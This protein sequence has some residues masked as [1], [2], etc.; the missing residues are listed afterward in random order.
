MMNKKGQWIHAYMREQR[1]LQRQQ[2]RLYARILTILGFDINELV[3]ILGVSSNT[4]KTYL[5]ETKSDFYSDLHEAIFKPEIFKWFTKEEQSLLNYIQESQEESKELSEE[6]KRTHRIVKGEGFEGWIHKKIFKDCDKFEKRNEEV[7][8]KIK[9]LAKEIK[10]KI[11]D[12]KN[13][14]KCPHLSK[15]K[16]DIGVRIEKKR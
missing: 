16:I 6:S 15:S 9:T 5:R 3:D 14:K 12:M 8:K 4:I 2:R 7:N 13:P 1:S 10:T 11:K